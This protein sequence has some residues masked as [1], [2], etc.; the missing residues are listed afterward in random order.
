MTREK[1]NMTE[2]ELIEGCLN[3][4]SLAQ[5]KL[6]NKYAPKMLG[7]CMRYNNNSAEAEDALQEGLIKVF[8]NLHSFSGSGSFEGWIRRIIVNTCLDSIR[9]NKNIKMHTPIDDVAYSLKSEQFILEG[10]AARDLIKILN[11]IPTGYRT[12]FNLYAIE[13][14]SHKEIANE[15][16]ITES[17]SKSQLS[18][19]RM[20]LR[21]IIKKNKFL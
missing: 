16:G 3:N 12:V 5:K 20:V 8:Q 7:V 15:L 2:D 19:A 14:Y 4:D 1:R 6:F 13:G 9:K 17:T 11:K 10:M 21:D 18:R